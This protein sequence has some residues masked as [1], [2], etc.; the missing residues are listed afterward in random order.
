MAHKIKAKAYTKSDCNKIK[1]IIS[2]DAEKGNEH[3]KLGKH[4]VKSSKKAKKIFKK[5]CK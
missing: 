3:I 1:R 2:S 4:M 5:Y